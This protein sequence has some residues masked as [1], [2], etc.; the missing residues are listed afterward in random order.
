MIKE[1]V[2]FLGQHSPVPRVGGIQKMC[3]HEDEE[4]PYCMSATNWE[5]HHYDEIKG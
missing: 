5:L 1:E 4:S 3:F 2:R